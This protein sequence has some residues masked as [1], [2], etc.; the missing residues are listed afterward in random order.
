MS[1][2][3]EVPTELPGSTVQFNK[4]IHTHNTHTLEGCLS[5]YECVQCMC[6]F[7]LSVSS[8]QLM[9]VA[10]MF[11]FIITGMSV[12]VSIRLSRLDDILLNFAVRVL[13]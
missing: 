3:Y 1:E 9:L 10:C 6:R 8:R 7:V 11:L 2:G 5:A 12:R 13:H 4:Y